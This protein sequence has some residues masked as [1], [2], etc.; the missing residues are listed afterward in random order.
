MTKRV[1]VTSL[2]PALLS[3]EEEPGTGLLSGLR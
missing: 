3:E 1:T 2:Q